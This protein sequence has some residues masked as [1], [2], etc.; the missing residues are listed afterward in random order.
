[1]AT[2]ERQ[3]Y[4]TDGK[5][6]HFSKEE[7]INEKLGRIIGEKFV[8]YRKKWN[9][10]HKLEKVSEFPLFLQ[11]HPDQNCNY[12]C[13]HCLIG[14]KELK[15]KYYDSGIDWDIYEKI[16]FEGEEHGCP[17]ISIQGWNEPLL[18]K[19]LEDYIKFASDHGFIDIMF[20]SNASLLTEQRSR[21][22]LDSGLTRIRF[23]LDAVTPETYEKVRLRKDYNR[24][25][26][27]INKF[28]QLRNEGGYQL[29]VVG[30]N[31]C[32]IS[33]NEH[34]VDTFRDFW[35]DKVDLV[36]IQT[37]MPPVLDPIFDQYYSSDQ[38][39]G[40]D[41]IPSLFKCPQ[42]F[43]RVDLHH[44]AIYPCCYYSNSSMKIGDLLQNTIYDAWNSK[45]AK[46]IRDIMR[47]GEYWKIK[48]CKDCVTSTFSSEYGS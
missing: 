43:E 11:I 34:E 48:T 5:V 22:L 12:K 32:K 29:P 8:N 35:E 45:K 23:S 21:N 31:F 30:V 42:P 20:N 6:T 44:T 26:G 39:K 15:K 47:K 4:T 7:E 18:M 46:A 14:Q 40:E 16:V 17:S 24:V 19:D 36:S 28:L 37:F 13:P 1:M 41:N 3:E 25:I 38:K 9:E 2:I 33:S 10:V 27:N